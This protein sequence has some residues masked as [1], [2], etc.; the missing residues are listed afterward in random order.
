MTAYG[1]AV[2]S[3]N[4]K[5]IT[6]EIKSVNSRYFDPSVKVSRLFSYLEERVK[7]Y[8]QKYI[9]RGK[10][11]VW[12][13]IEVVDTEGC[14][15]L[16]DEQYAASYIKAL[17]SLRDKFDLKD[18]ITVSRVASNKDIFVVVKPEEDIERIWSE[19]VPFVDEAIA[20]FMKMRAEEG[21]RLTE[22]I[23]QKKE[24]IKSLA[25]IIKEKSNECTRAYRDKL[26]SR[27]RALLENYNADIDET[28]LLTE[29]AIY[30]DKVAID[31]E[32]VRLDSH[33]V[34]FDS[35][36][37]SNEPVGRK[38][39]FLIQEINRESNTIGSKCSDASIAHIVVEIKSEIE[40]IREQVQNLE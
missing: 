35:I 13:G 31:E 27:I 11:D 26:E 29:C 22:D 19:V 6:V 39:D 7:S 18:D 36:I 25:A 14:E 21:A 24:N 17:Y 40:K 20:A 30:A 8:I 2:G 5:N 37:S 3:T 10:V 1:R 34:A 9:S 28:R 23:L 38:L 32:L 12:V 33:F 15:V 16:I 4:G